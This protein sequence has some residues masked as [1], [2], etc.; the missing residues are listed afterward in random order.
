M[1][2]VID[3]LTFAE[4]PRWRDGQLYFSD[5]QRWQGERAGRVV[6]V[7]ADGVARTVVDEVPGGPPS[8]LGWLPDGRL[9]MVATEGRQ[10]LIL[11]PDGTFTVHAD[12][13]KLATHPCN[14]MVVDAHGR[15][16]VG[17]CD[18]AGLPRPATSELIVV[19]PDG[20]ASVADPAMR[21]PNGSV[22][23]PDGRTLIVAETYGEGLTA[24]TIAADGTLSGKREWATVKGTYP[25]GICL[26]EAGRVWFAD[27]RGRACIRVVEGGEVLDRVETED[28]VYACTL[29][30]RT[31]YL[32][33]GLL[34][35]LAPEGSRPGRIFAHDVEVGASGSP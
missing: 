13:S 29:G 21:F 18:V 17:S 33:T 19:Q 26:D 12:L 22:I 32:L 30:D 2:L 27:A 15:A 5:L 28:R 7:T 31:L 6:A 23:T 24:F 9:L 10:L 20:E 1:R 11:E 3:N 8:G 4:G 14:D 16:Y 35:G 25:D 34:P